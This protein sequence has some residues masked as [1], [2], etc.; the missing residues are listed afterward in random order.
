VPAYTGNFKMLAGLS[1]ADM[2]L[3]TGGT[4]IA[5][6]NN[7]T[8][9]WTNIA[10]LGSTYNAAYFSTFRP[11]EQRVHDNTEE[12]F[13]NTTLVATRA[14]NYSNNL[15]FAYALDMFGNVKAYFDSI[16]V[17]KYVVPGPTVSPATYN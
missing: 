12:F 16:V 8:R 11:I 1:G 17:T 6:W 9:V 4:Q 5:W 10:F 7:T 2:S 3:I 15:S 14:V 13:I